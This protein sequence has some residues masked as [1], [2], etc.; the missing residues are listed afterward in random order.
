MN[1]II[2]CGNPT[3]KNQITNKTEVE[4]SDEYSEFYC[5]WDCAVESL[6]DK[7]R[8]VPFDYKDEAELQSKDIDIKK[9]NFYWKE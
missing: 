2:I 4:Y 5:N 6:F 1:S 7:A 8:C 9:G 3:C